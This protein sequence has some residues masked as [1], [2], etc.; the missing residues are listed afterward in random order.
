GHVQRRRSTAIERPAD[1]HATADGHVRNYWS[2][3]L[4]WFAA[5]KSHSECPAAA[6]EC[7]GR[8]CLAAATDRAAAAECV[9]HC[10][11][12]AATERLVSSRPSAAER[13]A[14]RRPGSRR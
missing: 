12:A 2:A 3:A 13:S 1:R 4:G 6:A 7:P 5:T 8:S 11:F 10:R 14:A 9:A